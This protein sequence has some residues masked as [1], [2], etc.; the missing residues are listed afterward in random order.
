MPVSCG[1][2]GAATAFAEGGVF[3]QGQTVPFFHTSAEPMRL[4]L[5]DF[6]KIAQSEEHPGVAGGT[7]TAVAMDA[8]PKRGSIFAEDR[9]ARAV[10]VA[11]GFLS[12]QAE[13][14]PRL[15]MANIIDQQAGGAAVVRDHDVDIAIVVDVA[16]GRPATDLEEGKGSSRTAGYVRESAVAIAVKQEFGLREGENTPFAC[17]CLDHGNAAI[18]HEQ[19]EMAVIIVVQHGDAKSRVA[20]RGE[21]DAALVGAILEPTLPVCVNVGVLASEIR[22]HQVLLSVA[23]QITRIDAHARVRTSIAIQGATEGQGFVFESAVML[24]DPELVGTQIVGDEDIGPAIAVEVGAYHSQGAI[25]LTADSGT[26]RYVLEGAVAAV[27]K[28]AVCKWF[29]RQWPAVVQRAARSKT[30]FQVRETEVD[31]VADEEIQPAVA[32]KINEG[33]AG[34]PTGSV[35][36]ALRGDI[37][38]RAIAVVTPH[39]IVAKIS[40]V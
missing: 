13:T 1:R 19:V 10:H 29:E 16:E 26:Y 36:A 18:D 20:S 3:A 34:A 27:A 15:L 22:D 6:C 7:V 11:I 8:T 35:G 31:I 4:D 24:I 12:H 5:S 23:E 38:K 40:D 2:L 37:G 32:V 21:G 30:L 39:L 9:D 25:E 17:L 28:E 33:G 14:D